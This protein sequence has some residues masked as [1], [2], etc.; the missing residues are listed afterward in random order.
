MYS[1]EGDDLGQVSTADVSFAIHFMKQ[2]GRMV[3][4]LKDHPY[5]PVTKQWLSTY[6]PAFTFAWEGWFDDTNPRHLESTVMIHLTH[7]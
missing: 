6:E 7:K 3:G 5:D 4:K 1:H 2:R